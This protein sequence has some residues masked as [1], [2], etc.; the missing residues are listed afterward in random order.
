MH[1]RTILINPARGNIIDSDALAQALREGWIWGAGVDVV[2]GEPN[3]GKDHV[4]V[5]EPRCESPF[6]IR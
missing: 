6:S 4:L 3:V 1:P 2:D 5:K